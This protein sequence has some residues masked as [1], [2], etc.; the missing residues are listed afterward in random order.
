[1]K[2]PLRTLDLEKKRRAFQFPGVFIKAPAVSEGTAIVGL[3]FNPLLLIL[4]SGSLPQRV[5]PAVSICGCTQR[6]P[7]RGGAAHE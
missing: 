5:T 2:L 7:Y 1:M 4:Q 6:Y 3:A